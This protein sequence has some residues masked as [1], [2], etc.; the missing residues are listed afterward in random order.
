MKIILNDKQLEVD[1]L[2]LQELVAEIR[3]DLTDEIIDQICV[4]GE[5]V[6]ED[7]LISNYTVSEVDEIEFVTKKSID[8]V[9][10][11]L[12]EANNYLPKLKEGIIDTANLFSKGEIVNGNDKFQLCLDGIE[13][14]SNVLIQILSLA[15]QDDAEVQEEKKLEEFNVI[16]KKVLTKMQEDDLNQAAELLKSEVAEYIEEFIELNNELLSKLK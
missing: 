2:D 8:L 10:E 4:D 6:T 9:K 13:W 11:T 16:I 14:Y 1:N 12:Q 5:E 15:Y 3:E 7:E